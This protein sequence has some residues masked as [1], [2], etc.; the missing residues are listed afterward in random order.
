MKEVRYIDVSELSG[1]FGIISPEYDIVYAGTTVNAMP[2]SLNNAEYERF[3]K[4]H[5]I[6]FIFES[7]VPKIDFFACPWVEIFAAD[8]DGS[9]FG[10]VGG[11]EGKVCY[12]SCE[13]EVFIAAENMADFISE[14]KR[15]LVKA[16]DITLFCDRTDAE[17]SIEFLE[18]PEF[19]RR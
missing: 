19:C 17:K 3:E 7:N 15:A 4:E 12:I 2:D 6:R 1:A 13:R 11:H 18:L 10:I 14:K 16:D 8:D 9:L 5:R